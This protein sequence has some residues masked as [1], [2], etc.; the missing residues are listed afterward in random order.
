MLWAPQ[1]DI[2]SYLESPEGQL[3]TQD[4]REYFTNRTSIPWLSNF[5]LEDFE[6]AYEGLAVQDSLVRALAGVGARLLAGTDTNPL[7]YVLHRELR[8]LVQA[9]LTPFQALE[10]ATSNPAGFLAL[11]DGSGTI[12]VGSRADLVMIEAN[13]LV[14]ISSTSRIAWVVREGLLIKP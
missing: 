9:G 10:A 1:D 5:S 7:G 4:D 13:P 14:D 11:A 8:E 12:S 3:L 6:T 2:E